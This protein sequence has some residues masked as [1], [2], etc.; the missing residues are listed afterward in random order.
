MAK[1]QRY[2]T[3]EGWVVQA[4]CFALDLTAAQSRITDRSGPVPRLVE[5]L[6]PMKAQ[7]GQAKVWTCDGCAAVHDRDDN[8]A[9]NLARW[10]PPSSDLGAVAAPVKRG[11]EHKTRPRR[12][13]GL[14]TRKPWPDTSDRSNLVRGA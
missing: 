13:V 4:F 3:P 6:P 11:A 2:K 12:A 10:T 7:P 14:D 1:G 8:A 9:I 5:N